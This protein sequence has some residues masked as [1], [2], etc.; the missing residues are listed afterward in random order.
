MPIRLVSYGYPIAEASISMKDLLVAATLLSTSLSLCLN[1]ASS[2]QTYSVATPDGVGSALSAEAPAPPAVQVSK[3]HYRNVDFMLVAQ[4]APLPAAIPLKAI[5]FAQPQLVPLKIAPTVVPATTKPMKPPSRTHIKHMP[6]ATPPRAAVTP[7]AGASMKR[8]TTTK[9]QERKPTKQSTQ[10]STTTVKPTIAQP[11]PAT[12]IITHVPT[13]NADGTDAKRIAL[14]FDDGPSPDYTPQVLALLK[15]HGI[16]ATF[17]LVGRQV[18]KH[19]ELVQQIV[20]EG[21]KVANHSMNHD[22]HLPCRS[23]AKLQ[24]EV[25]AEK[26]LIESVVPGT[27]VS[28]FRAPAG[29]WD[30]HMRKVIL[31]WGMKPLGWS[32]DTKDWQQPGTEAIVNMVNNRIHSGAVILMHDGGGNRSQ[33]VAALKQFIPTLKESGYNFVV[34]E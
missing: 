29:N 23:D 18:K 19:P 1:S 13:K 20:A 15:K 33:S 6:T 16:K 11:P 30:L 8:T 17:C 28:Y 27:K 26:A 10:L 12:R 9:S 3:V 34:P 5:P 14:T 2:A 21:H 24:Q 4:L 7:S 22:E 32:I 25:L 31:G